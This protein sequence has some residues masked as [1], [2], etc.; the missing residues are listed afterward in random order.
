MSVD[1]DPRPVSS[2]HPLLALVKGDTVAPETAR[3]IMDFA[4]G[5]RG[6]VSL[7]DDHSSAHV[8]AELEL[9]AGL[10]DY[11]IVQDTLMEFLPQY[12]DGP[13]LALAKWLP[14]HPE[15]AIDPDPVPS[16][17]P[18]GWLRRVSG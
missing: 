4:A 8:L 5:E 13:H 15:F 10:A 11:L 17:H 18:G 2:S 9:Y 12:A 1:N 7:D 3:Q 14:D 16:N 6:L